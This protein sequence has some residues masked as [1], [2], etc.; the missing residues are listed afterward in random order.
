ML[1]IKVLNH[2]ILWKIY[3]W[4]LFVLS[5]YG[6][7]LSKSDTVFVFSRAQSASENVKTLSL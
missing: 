7:Y 2:D 6:I 5:G 1:H 4:Y 3:R